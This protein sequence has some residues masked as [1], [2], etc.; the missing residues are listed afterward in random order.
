M[1]TAIM[2]GHITKDAATRTVTVKGA[3]VLVTD[4]TVAVNEGYGDTQQTDYVVCSIWRDRGAKL[5]QHL[6]KGR[7][8]VLKG[9]VSSRAWIGTKGENAGKPM[10]QLVMSNP[11]IEFTAAKPQ[12]EPDDE[13]PF[14]PDEDLDA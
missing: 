7:S 5:A 3:P 12:Q 13:I 11:A 10:S 14:L 2:I 1:N 9:R 8:V 6:T 4:F